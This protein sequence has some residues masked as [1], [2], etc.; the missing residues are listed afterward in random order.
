MIKL[1]DILSE[2]ITNP[3][4]TNP[5][6]LAKTV[7]DWFDFYTDYIDD[8]RKQ[9]R[10]IQQND[11]TLEWFNSH[12][13]DIKQ[14]AYKMMLSQAKGDKSKIEGTFGKYLKEQVEPMNTEF[15]DFAKKR[16]EGATKISDNAKEKGGPAMLTHYHF[17]VKLPYYE[18]AANGEF[19]ID[20]T[21]DEL[22]SYTNTF[23]NLDEN[24]EIDQIA[25]QKLVGI[26]EVLGELIIKYREIK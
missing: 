8:G 23:C 25:F 6:E 5:N 10:A 18:T 22:A 12:P 20:S 4:E 11:S 3:K 1:K 14:K 21:K 19:D 17:V 26:I 2:A 16:L 15:I 24:V 13:T 7:L 9:R